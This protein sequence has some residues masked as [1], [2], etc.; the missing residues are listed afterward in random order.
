M[1]GPGGSGWPWV[2][3]L[4]GFGGGGGLGRGL[5]PVGACG[6]GLVA[7]GTGWPGEGVGGLGGGGGWFGKEFVPL[8]EGRVMGG[9]GVAGRPEEGVLSLGEWWLA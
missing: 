8:C 2:E 6:R 5:V 4:G 1:A 3:G 9:L 7:W